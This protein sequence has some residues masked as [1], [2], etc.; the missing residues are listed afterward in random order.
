MNSE[1]KLT[2]SRG[3]SSESIQQYHNKIEKNAVS[4]KLHMKCLSRTNK[5]GSGLHQRIFKREKMKDQT[6]LTN[7]STGIKKN[8]N[9]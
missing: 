6:Q 5:P 4:I 9:S 3:E 7:L 1:S 8:N 2:D